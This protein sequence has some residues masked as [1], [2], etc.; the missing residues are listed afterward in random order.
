MKKFWFLSLVLAAVVATAF[1]FL[2]QSADPIATSD[3]PEAGDRGVEAVAP[4]IV[5]KVT[6]D[7]VEEDATLEVA[8]PATVS[9]SPVA[10]PK[11]KRLAGKRAT[12]PQQADDAAL[13]KEADEQAPPGVF[14]FAKPI[15]VNYTPE[16]SGEWTEGADNTAV[17]S[18]EV[19]SEAAQSLNFGFTKYA[20]PAGGELRLLEE[21]QTESRYRSF[22]AADN[23]SHGQLWTPLLSGD[24]VTVE[25]S[26]PTE[27]K[28]DL[29]LVLSQVNHGFRG[30]QPPKAGDLEKVGTGASSDCQ[31]DV[32]CDSSTY[33]A[34]GAVI[35][36]YA[37]QSRAV[38]AVTLGGFDACSGAAINNARNDNT[39]YFLTCAHVNIDRSNAPSMVVYWNFENSTCRPLGDA[40]NAA[41]GDG[42]TTDF[43]SGATFCSSSRLSDFCLV[44]LDDPIDP[45]YN[46]HFAGWDRSTADPQSAV[47]IHHPDVAEKRISIDDDPASTTKRFSDQKKSDGRFVRVGDWEHGSSEGGSSG[48]PLF[49]ENGLIVGQLLGGFSDC[50]NSEPDWFGRVSASWDGE[51]AYW[52]RLSD[53]LDPDDTGATSLSGIDQSNTLSVSEV[54]VT[55]G[56]SGTTAAEFTITLARINDDVVTVDWLSAHLDTDDS[57]FVPTTGSLSFAAGETTKTVTIDIIADSDEEVD[58]TFYVAIGNAVSAITTF[59]YGIGTISNDDFASVPVITSATTETLGE[60]DLLYY[61]IVADHTPQTFAISGEPTD[62]EVDADGLVTWTATAAGTY[63]VLL[64]ATSPAGTGSATLTVEVLPRSIGEAVDNSTYTY[65]DT[66]DFPMQHTTFLSSNGGDSMT[67]P[68]LLDGESAGFQFTVN[69][70]DHLVFDWRVSSEYGADFFS[71]IVNGQ[72][73]KWIHGEVDWTEA[74]VELPA[75]TNTVE[76]RYAKD[77]T[78]SGGYDDAHVDNIR[79]ASSEGRP[80][81]TSRN[82][83]E[84]VEGAPFSTQVTTDKGATSITVEGLPEGLE[85]D[86]SNNWIGGIPEDHG[87]F[88]VAITAENASG[89]SSHV[90]E[91]DVARRISASLPSHFGGLSWGVFDRTG[92]KLSDETFPRPRSAEIAD[93]RSSY[94]ATIVNG[95]GEL[96]LRLEASSEQNGDYLDVYVNGQLEQSLSGSVTQ[97]VFLDLP[98]SLCWVELV[99]SKDLSISSGDDAGFLNSVITSRMPPL[100]V[101]FTATQGLSNHVVLSWDEQSFTDYYIYRAPVDDSSQA[102]GLAAVDSDTYTDTTADPAKEYYYWMLA[103]N[104]Y[105]ISFLSNSELGYRSGALPTAPLN[106]SAADGALTSIDVSWD[107]VVNATGYRVLRST[108]ASGPW[109]VLAEVDAGTLAYSDSSSLTNGVL[110]YYSIEAR[111]VMGY[112]VAGVDTGSLRA[113]APTSLQITSE[114]TGGVTMQWTAPSYAVSGYTILRSETS[115]VSAAIQVGLVAGDVLEFRD[116]SGESG[117]QYYY[118]VEATTDTGVQ[119]VPSAAASGSTA[120]VIAVGGGL[121]DVAGQQHLF[122]QFT[123]PLS[124]PPGYLFELSEDMETWTPVDPVDMQSVGTAEPYDARHEKI[125]MR[126]NAPISPSVDKQFLRVTAQPQ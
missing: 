23:E 12:M 64:D 30:I 94:M 111:N 105:G 40:S 69:G 58:E 119:S 67:T 122:I 45:S 59:Y 46:V 13:A 63:S 72:Y 113:A 110:Y 61:Q 51:G 97:Y 91:L 48:S 42:L 52:N 43:S 50:G 115:D 16:N 99:Y 109:D 101:E 70:P 125:S 57:D 28:D 112:G 53:W 116:V 31:V 120:F 44:Q 89:S 106:V 1:V 11:P 73:E 39:P 4:E 66:G 8:A 74:V 71:V 15:Y 29:Q 37:N 100:P 84:C 34:A 3:S 54:S 78:D 6:V 93:G 98:D 123:Q 76:F 26:V 36:A 82:L 87:I 35:E 104:N 68:R 117:Q 126:L 27:K 107:A 102:V 38:G 19:E 124:D 80:F 56:D 86:P 25:V 18:L 49:N 114:N 103:Q 9:L 95:P 62:M 17:W 20:M 81:V 90:L 5:K 85:F 60:G 118:F 33:P 92:W 77:I 79:L 96:T 83:S 24:V 108:S 2:N 75:G 32:A 88:E 10:T 65:T 22:T 14:R 21:G 121:M 7:P 55:E 41:P 47:C